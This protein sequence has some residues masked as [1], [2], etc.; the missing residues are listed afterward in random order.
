M[1]PSAILLLTP[2]RRRIPLVV[3]EASFVDAQTEGPV[4]RVGI[5]VLIIRETVL[6]GA[7]NSCRPANLLSFSEPCEQ[8]ERHYSVSSNCA[9]DAIE[10]KLE[11]AMKLRS[12]AVKQG[13]SDDAAN[14]RGKLR[15]V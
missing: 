15:Q 10:K 1:R 8:F 2:P 7:M 3:L 11:T 5:E 4:C 14:L 9:S 13:A 12:I 6:A